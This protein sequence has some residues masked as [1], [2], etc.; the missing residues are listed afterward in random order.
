MIRSTRRSSTKPTRKPIL[1]PATVPAASCAAAIEIVGNY[2]MNVT[3][4]DGHA[5]S[6]YPFG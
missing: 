1:D 3:W 6:I 5:P 4:C 2:G